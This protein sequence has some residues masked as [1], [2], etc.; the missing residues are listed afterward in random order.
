[1]F[2]G[3]G[4]RDAGFGKNLFQIADPGSKRPRIPDPDPQLIESADIE[5]YYE[6]L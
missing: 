2:W 4:I 6:I 1:M 3:S 5:H